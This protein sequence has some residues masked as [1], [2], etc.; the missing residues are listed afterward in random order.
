MNPSENFA[1]SGVKQGTVQL[2]PLSRRTIRFRILP[3]VSG[4]WIR[5]L[6]VV[7]DRYFQ[8]I[9]KVIPT[10]GMMADKKGVLVWVPAEEAIT[11][12]A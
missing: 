8:K 1:F 11:E 7:T 5:P 10:E 9:L 12:S 4:D 6:F 2:L 3:S